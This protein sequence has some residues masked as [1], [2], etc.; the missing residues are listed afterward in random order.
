MN[1]KKQIA[2]TTKARRELKKADKMNRNFPYRTHNKGH[3]NRYCAFKDH[4]FDNWLFS[5]KPFSLYFRYN[6]YNIELRV[7]MK[8]YRLKNMQ[9]PS[10]YFYKYSTFRFKAN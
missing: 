6:P 1:E 4:V 10:K 9:N 3:Y 2:L 8:N 5:D 7:N